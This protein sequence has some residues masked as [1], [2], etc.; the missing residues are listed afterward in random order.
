MRQHPWGCAVII[1]C[2]LCIVIFGLGVSLGLLPIY[3]TH[4]LGFSP[5]IV[6]GVVGVESAST[7]VSRLPAGRF[8][9]RHGPKC[10][11]L[12]GLGLT[13]ISGAICLLAIILAS[14]TG[15]VTA[16]LLIL[17][18]RIV[19]GI[20]ESLVFTCSGTWP[21]ALIG[22][23][24]AGKVM[25]MVGI[26]MFIGLAAGNGVGGISHQGYLSLTT[27]ALLMSVLP[28]IGLLIAAILPS[29]PIIETSA[30][31]SLREVVTRVWP[32]GAGF[33]LSNMGYA[34]IVSFLMVLF[35]AKG[36]ESLSTLALVMYSIGYVLSRATV[37]LYTAR[38]GK[39]TTFLM[40]GIE[41]VG[42]VLIAYAGSWHSSVG[43]FIAIAGSFLTGY[44]LSMVYPL[45]GV[46]AI[47][48]LPASHTGVAL[49]AYEACF[50]IG[51]LLVGC[52]S[53]VISAWGYSAIFVVAA[54]CA[55]LA[56]YCA[57]RAWYQY[58]Q[59][60]NI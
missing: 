14:S 5:L 52:I 27:S 18:S 1:S 40:L 38:L 7:L 43:A 12:W 47:G 21:I 34:A 35:W 8:S 31:I 20:G 60:Q 44:G 26:G 25:S 4:E 2:L 53:G 9:D 36:W 16:L 37:G 3:L 48:C 23:E 6:S 32:A 15:P 28:A 55:L 57:Q 24:N 54:G 46:T 33:A 41:A 45:L 50:D 11:M 30:S 22:R 39:M 58:Q 56:I 51:I 19:M 42:L 10:G 29:V 13:S 59:L 17:I 49:S